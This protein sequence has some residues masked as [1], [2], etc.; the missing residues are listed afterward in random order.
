M[1]NPFSDTSATFNEPL[2][3]L[4]ACHDRMR[5]QLATLERLCRHLPV[6]GADAEAQKAARNIMKYFDTAAPNHHADEEES[7][8]P[9]LAAANGQA[10]SLIEALSA[11][12][13][14]LDA[15]W[16]HLRPD[17]AGIAA[18]RR[19]VLT[20]DLVR[21]IR[22]AYTAH[23]EREE[24]ELLPL[25]AQYFDAATLKMIGA[26]MAAR[27]GVSSANKM[28]AQPLRSGLAA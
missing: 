16:D 11:E 2:E 28:P 5:Q 21:R 4:C 13:H 14:T 1:A 19:S 26:E 15:L 9:R 8:F 7:L 27:R 3:M 6:N 23:I 20:P 24:G 18:G 17:L 22:E 12:H 10:R 25:A